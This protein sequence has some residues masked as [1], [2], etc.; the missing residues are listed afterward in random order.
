MTGET[1]FDNVTVQCTSYLFI[2]KVAIKV[3][4]DITGSLFKCEGM[5][6]ARK[7]WQKL[8]TKLDHTISDCFV[9]LY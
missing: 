9:A 6:S 2:V 4:M 8:L 1:G 7:Y 3:D 5:F